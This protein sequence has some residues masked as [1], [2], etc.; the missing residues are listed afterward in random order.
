MSSTLPDLYGA[1]ADPARLRLLSLLAAGGELC[2]CDL[3]RVLDLPQTTASRHLA[4]LRAAGLVRV[5][6]S[7]TWM[8]YALADPAR[9]HVLAGLAALRAID[10]QLEADAR[11]LRSDLRSGQCVAPAVLKAGRA[12]QRRASRA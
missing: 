3:H 4:L 10:P 7:G 1:L 8:L 12:A 9:R 11:R 2:V 5:R 6:R